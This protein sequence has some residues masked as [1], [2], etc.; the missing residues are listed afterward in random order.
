[1]LSA[2]E[3]GNNLMLTRLT[4]V[5][6]LIDTKQQ[7]TTTSYSTQIA[8]FSWHLCNSR[9]A[10]VESP[11]HAKWTIIRKSH[12]RNQ[13]YLCWTNPKTLIG[14]SIAIT[15]SGR[16]SVKLVE[17][18]VAVG[19]P[20][21]LTQPRN[22]IYSCILVLLL[23]HELFQTSIL[24]ETNKFHHGGPPWSGGPGAIAPVAPPLNPALHECR[25][26]WCAISVFCFSVSVDCV[27]QLA[28][29]LRAGASSLSV[30]TVQTVEI[31]DPGNN[32]SQ[33]KRFLA[34]RYSLA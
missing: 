7:S 15:K 18:S 21:Y 32:C 4:P 28:P 13:T 31:V 8:T 12:Q 22:I 9:D 6:T 17:K 33:S 24:F 5:A 34:T 3:E 20:Q 23:N 1:M 27:Y 11:T 16:Q 30:R 26:G 25:N 2:V 19:D 14:H 10:R 29:T